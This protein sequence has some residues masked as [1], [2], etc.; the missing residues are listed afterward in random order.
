M[1]KMKSA[2]FTKVDLTLYYDKLDNGLEVYIVPKTN[3]NN[4]Y[5]TFTSKFGS[6]HYE[7]VPIDGNKMIKVPEGVAHF[8]E[9]KVFEQEDGIDPFAFYSER[10]ADINANTSNHK[11]TYH[12]SSTDN[13]EENLEFLLDFVQTPY[14]T[15]KNVEKEKGIIEQE[16]KMYE[17]DPFYVLYHQ[18]LTNCIVKHPIRIPIAGTVESINKI[19]KEDLYTCYNTFYHPSNMFVVVTGNVNPEY[20]LNIIKRNQEKKNFPK[21]ENPIKVKQYNEPDKVF[22]EKEIIEMNVATPKVANAYKLN[23]SHIKDLSKMKII[24]FILSYFDI[25]VGSTSE[26]NEALKQEQI[27]HYNLD[28]ILVNLDTHIIMMIVSDTQRPEEL[29]ERLRSEISKFDIT[30]EEFERKKK[31]FISSYIYLSD[32]IYRINGKVMGNIINEGRVITNDYEEIKNL[33][34]EDLKR[35]INSI[36]FE[37][38]NYVIINPKK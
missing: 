34:F 21:V 9:H 36:S 14:F 11:T 25:K 15:D 32:N 38:N 16:I 6:K 26:L 24:D 23:I 37:N 29:V 13:L 7:F 19:T 3:V 8:L 1:N 30:E 20:V 2:E 4:I 17:D 10:G 22:K 18:T 27:I 33:K 12:F 31:T 5:V 28:Y 35:V